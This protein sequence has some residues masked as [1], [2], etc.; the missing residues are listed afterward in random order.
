M[1]IPQEIAEEVIKGS[2]EEMYNTFI[3]LEGEYKEYRKDY[4][5]VRFGI[6]IEYDIYLNWKDGRII[7]KPKDNAVI[8]NGDVYDEAD[9]WSDEEERRKIMA[10]AIIDNTEVRTKISPRGEE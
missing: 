10:K 1:K 2:L 8:I 6:I 4:Q 9:F 7:E 5:K 3:N